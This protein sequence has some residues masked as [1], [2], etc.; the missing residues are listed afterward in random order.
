MS[1]YT[2]ETLDKLLKKDLISIVHVPDVNLASPSES[3]QGIRS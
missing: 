3:L 1:K 2:E